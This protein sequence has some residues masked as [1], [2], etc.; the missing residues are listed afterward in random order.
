MSFEKAVRSD[1]L[2]HII[3][4][5]Q[6]VDRTLVLLHHVVALHP[7]EHTWACQ[8]TNR[9]HLLPELPSMH[10]WVKEAL[11]SA[12]RR[13]SSGWGALAMA[14]V[15]K[16]EASR[17][18][19]LSRHSIDKS[20]HTTALCWKSA[21]PGTSIR[22][23]ETATCRIFQCRFAER[24]GQLTILLE[25]ADGAVLLVVHVPPLFD[26]PGL[27]ALYDAE[28]KNMVQQPFLIVGSPA[29]TD[30]SRLLGM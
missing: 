13:S 30:C 1:L 12:S 26:K 6:C 27:Q 9:G 2:V 28:R 14:C 29:K 25:P 11:T 18:W 22:H 5:L 15:R 20:T 3:G 19:Q 17:Y 21:A 23:R 24:D 8:S 16:V 4:P 7:H 10:G